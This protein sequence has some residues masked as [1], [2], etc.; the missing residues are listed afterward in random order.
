[1]HIQNKLSSDQDKCLPR[2]LHVLRLI[3]SHGKLDLQVL[4]RA[5]FGNS[6]FV[7]LWLLWAIGSRVEN[8]LQASKS[9][10]L[11]GKI[12]HKMGFNGE[13]KHIRWTTFAL[14]VNLELYIHISE[15]GFLMLF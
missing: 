1:M 7:P 5:V 14:K 2:V 3:H 11:K 4:I 10:M 12:I 13:Q 9:T 15:D 6:H 8:N